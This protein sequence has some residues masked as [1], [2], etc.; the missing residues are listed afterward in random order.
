MYLLFAFAFGIT[1]AIITYKLLVHDAIKA[2]KQ[3]EAETNQQQVI[4][5][6]VLDQMRGAWLKT[7]RANTISTRDDQWRLTLKYDS[8]IKAQ[9]IELSNAQGTPDDIHI[10]NEFIPVRDTIYPP[11]H[12]ALSHEGP[13]HILMTMFFNAQWA[14]PLSSWL[15]HR[16]T[17]SLH[18][19]DAGL[20]L[21]VIVGPLDDDEASL[22]LLIISLITTM[23]PCPVPDQSTCAQTSLAIL[24]GEAAS[25]TK[26]DLTSIQAIAFRHLLTQTS[27]D[28]N[29]RQRA[30]ALPITST[31]PGILYE[32]SVVDNTPLQRL[33][34]NSLRHA[35]Y[36]EPDGPRRVVALHALIS[37]LSNS[38]LLNLCNDLLSKTTPPL[39]SAAIKL[40]FEHANQEERMSAVQRLLN[41]YKDP[42]HQ[43]HLDGWLPTV[44]LDHPLHQSLKQ[45]LLET[46]MHTLIAMRFDASTPKD[47]YTLFLQLGPT[48]Y[49]HH[50]APFASWLERKQIQRITP[51]LAPDMEALLTQMVKESANSQLQGVAAHTLA[52]FYIQ[53]EQGKQKLAKL[54]TNLPLQVLFQNAS[55]ILIDVL[56]ENTEDTTEA[57][58]ELDDLLWEMDP[59]PSHRTIHES[60]INRLSKH[61]HFIQTTWTH[62]GSTHIHLEQNWQLILNMP[63]DQAITTITGIKDT[64]SK[65]PENQ[66]RLSNLISRGLGGP[67]YMSLIPVF[68]DVPAELYPTYQAKDLVDWLGQ[69]PD[70][71]LERHVE[72]C[73][74]IL[75][76][77]YLDDR[78]GSASYQHKIEAY[79][80]H[81][82]TA[83]LL[84]ELFP[85]QRDP[86][87]MHLFRTLKEKY[88]RSGGLTLS[89]GSEMDGALSLQ[90]TQDGQL[91]P[92]DES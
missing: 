8:K 72:K 87:L 65:M 5:L 17:A 19:N 92:T 39:A 18:I 38:E 49:Q 41:R 7:N 10:T 64:L 37:K 21:K 79:L 36:H 44:P 26:T 55:S 61:E 75:L 69:Q 66:D 45:A 46:S 15:T 54:I 90:Q 1:L 89:V 20:K 3:L 57:L 53:S 33:E 11:L 9:V 85:R 43:D 30:E 81:H 70:G 35:V 31:H 24:T 82:G 40:T 14:T 29:F 62:P 58:Q 84:A 76:D 27:P 60:I 80:L 51:Q 71:A 32:Q 6:E 52:D 83:T 23:P 12:T 86:R 68:Y 67:L 59:A 47:Q 2:E 48:Q 74:F 73:Q 22:T 4:L 25:Q 50:P 91:T 78:L 28:N 42:K 88:Q 13:Y 56:V 16:N 63:L 77:I 34:A